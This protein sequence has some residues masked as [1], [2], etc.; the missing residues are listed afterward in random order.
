M[1]YYKS[2]QHEN[3]P[4]FSTDQQKQEAELT[5]E[6][7]SLKVSDFGLLGLLLLLVIV[8]IGIFCS[9]HTTLQTERNVQVATISSVGALVAVAL[10]T[11]L[12]STG[13]NCNWR[14]GFAYTV[15]GLTGLVI[16]ATP[17][18]LFA[19]ADSTTQTRILVT[20]VIAGAL[21]LCATIVSQVKECGWWEGLA[22]SLVYIILAVTCLFLIVL[23]MLTISSGNNHRRHHLTVLSATTMHSR[24]QLQQA[25]RGGVDFL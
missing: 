17:V 19:M 23:I 9:I 25:F 11:M 18:I 1:I 3:S 4:Q 21:A 7:G 14:E 22:Y 5:K 8:V 16:C 6:Q 2:S 24:G 10:A 15:C 13:L 20:I 12:I